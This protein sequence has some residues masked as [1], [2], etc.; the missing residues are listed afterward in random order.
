MTIK[1]SIAKAAPAYSTNMMRLSLL[2]AL[3]IASLI[4]S[5]NVGAYQDSEPETQE[6]E[7]TTDVETEAVKK[8]I[9]RRVDNNR[10]FFL[11]ERPSVKVSKGPALGK[12]KTILPKPFVPRG[13]VELPA[14]IEETTDPIEDASTDANIA[15]LLASADEDATELLNQDDDIQSQ[16]QQTDTQ[17]D[18][19]SGDPLISEAELE[20]Y[21]PSSAG[22]TN[23]GNPIGVDFWQ[24]YS[25][26]DYIA[27]L[28]G[29]K[30]TN[31]SP[32]LGRLAKDIALSGIGIPEA[33]DD[34]QINETVKARLNLI[35]SLGDVDD[36][37]SLIS[38]LP[39]D[40]DWSPLAREFADAH[41]LA[42][43]MA[44]ACD[45]ADR[46]RKT[47]QSAYWL[48]LAAFC[49]AANGNRTAVDFELGILEEVET[50]EPTFYRLMDYILFEA[51]QNASGT[52]IEQSEIPPLEGPL[53]IDILESAMARL[54]RVQISEFK[55][56]N[57]NPLALKIMLATPTVDKP[58]KTGLVHMAYQRGWLKEDTLVTFFQNYGASDEEKQSAFALGA[59]EPGWQVDATLA[60]L[61]T[62]NA[63]ETQKIDAIDILWRRAVQQRATAYI[64]SSL[65]KIAGNIETEQTLDTGAATLAKVALVAGD[66]EKARYWLRSLR[67]RSGGDNTEADKALFS[68]WPLMTIGFESDLKFNQFE[69][70]W[71]HNA[72]A[73]DRYERANMLLTILEANGAT[74]PD[75]AWE[76]LEDGP[77]IISGASAAPAHWRRFLIAAS[78][79]NRPQTLATAF[80][81]FA[82][83]QS[84]EMPA[85]LAGSL[86][87][88]L[89]DL[90]FNDVAK[91]LAIE[92]L[93]AQDL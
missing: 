74:V 19:A 12:P 88:T 41:L 47:D 9:I 59:T 7:Q 32:T 93:V 8:P 81:L 2:G 84:G 85:S 6:N 71:Q 10:R 55:L 89:R 62:G 53:A 87:G 72:E 67:T 33:A 68:L 16:E 23:D 54:A 70:W 18:T 69:R 51:E 86:I 75:A 31:G 91:K 25:R 37:L 38:N 14:P 80:K 5:H 24:G 39:R 57:V 21:D 78:Q 43:H 29:F 63:E 52:T 82:P 60:N 34:A 30:D 56:E 64:A 83:L 40:H 49:G 20:A 79:D 28:D 61:L 11:G 58:A 50:V 1:N 65:N 13:S 26:A 66:M 92:I 42:G 17:P 48:R 45:V 90:G 22:V 44:D 73:S 76:V 46:E 3:S 4:L 36:Y 15:N 77:A 35:A 27:R